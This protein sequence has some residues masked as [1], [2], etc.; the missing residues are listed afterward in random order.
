MVK[1]YSQ[2][3]RCSLQDRAACLENTLRN[4]LKGYVDIRVNLQFR[5]L[6]QELTVLHTLV[7]L[8]RIYPR[9]GV[10]LKA[11]PLR[12]GCFSLCLLLQQGT[13]KIFEDISERP[14]LQVLHHSEIELENQRQ[15][16]TH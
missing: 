13:N 9:L 16:G 14:P 15:S 4:A 10:P 7:P 11:H 3:Q 2:K 1:G 8:E 12:G 5:T 6:N